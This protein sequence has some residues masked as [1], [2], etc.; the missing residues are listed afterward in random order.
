[1]PPIDFVAGVI[2]MSAAE[3]DQI[4]AIGIPGERTPSDDERSGG[5]GIPKR[6]KF[7]RCPDVRKIIKICANPSA[8]GGILDLGE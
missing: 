7:Q 4:A 2:G 6:L 8:I 1:M 3:K 5:T